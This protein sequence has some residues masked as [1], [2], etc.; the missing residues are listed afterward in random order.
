[1]VVWPHVVCSPCFRPLFLPGRALVAPCF[2]LASAG[3]TL[4]GYV[5]IE[6]RRAVASL[7][8]L[9][10][11]ATCDYCL[12]LGSYV[13]V[14]LAL[15]ALLHSALPLVSL[16]LKDLAL[17]DQAFVNDLVSILW[18]AELNSN[19]RE[20]FRGYVACQPSYVLDLCLRNERLVI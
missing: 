16:A 17:P 10:A 5:P 7:V 8:F 14:V 15:K 12:A 3:G 19:A 20:G 11:V 18:P 9:R 13:A 4:P 2:V 1:V 6:L